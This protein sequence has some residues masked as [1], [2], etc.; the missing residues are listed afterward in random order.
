[1]HNTPTD[2]T[3]NPSPLKVAEHN[4][5]PMEFR[6][7]PS[8]GGQD[9]PTTVVPPDT[10]VV[11][12]EPQYLAITTTDSTTAVT[13]VDNAHGSDEHLQAVV[14]VDPSQQLESSLV[15]LRDTYSYCLFC[16]CQYEDQEDMMACCPGTNEEDHE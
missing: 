6:A 14:M 11:D 4:L 7:V 5:W 8:E 2:D 16:G 13:K 15:Y 9:Q 10:D 3:L 1:M 12:E